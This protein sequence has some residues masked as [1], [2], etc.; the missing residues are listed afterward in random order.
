MFVEIHLLQ[1]FAPSNLNRDDTGSPKD[2]E[3]GGARRARISSQCLKRAMR[4][5]PSFA[6]ATRV[7]LGQRTKRMVK[8]LRDKLETAGKSPEQAEAVAAAFVEKYA[9]KFDSK[10]T[11]ANKET[12]TVVLLYVAEGELQTIAEALCENWDKLTTGDKAAETATAQLAKDLTKQHKEV[13]SAPDI[14]LFGRMLAEKPE[15]NLNAACQVAHA[16]STHRV[17]M[18]MDFYTAVDDLLGRDEPGAGMMGVQ[19]YDSACYYRYARIDWEQL[20]KNLGGDKDAAELALKTVDGFLQASLR[21]VPSGKQNSHAAYNP[22]SLALAVVRKDGMAWNL[23]NA[24]EQ[25]VR[26]EGDSGYVAPSLKRLDGYWGELCATYGQETLLS[27][28][29]LRCGVGD[30]ELKH[31]AAHTVTG[32]AA[33]RQAV[34]NALQNGG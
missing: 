13:T 9:S 20:V 8:L 25:P 32:E 18:E 17:A 6:A 10:T 16:L 14:A 11:G 24:F 28:S 34:L 7:P 5:D 2:C 22:P 30:V 31:L 26:A 1:S 33:W 27:V 29:V 12:Q 15:L 21:A 23:A 19:G 4:T 3:F